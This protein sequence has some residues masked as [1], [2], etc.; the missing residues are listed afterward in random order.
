MDKRTL[1][2]MG[3]T[4]G[5]EHVDTVRTKLRYTAVLDEI[6]RCEEAAKLREP[7]ID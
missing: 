7:A 6:G 3:A 4:L 2:G 1:A 5:K